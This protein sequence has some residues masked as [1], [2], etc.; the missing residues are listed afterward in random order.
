MM[1][2]ELV[3]LPTWISLG[4]IAIILTVT[5]VA[6]LRAE[7]RDPT[8]PEPRTTSVV[9][10]SAEASTGASRGTSIMQPRPTLAFGDD[11]S[12]AA[13]V[14][15]LWII[16]HTWTGWRLEIITAQGAPI[17]PPP[18][19]EDATL[20]H[21]DP[22]TPRRPFA[23]TAFGDV[24]HLTA[25]IDPRLALWRPADLLV[26]GPRGPG[27]LKALHLGSTAEWLLQH[28]IAP[29]VIARSGHPARKVV[30]CHDG[31]PTR[32]VP[33]NASRSSP[34]SGVSK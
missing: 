15:W 23:E 25:E 3:H 19:P 5:I 9:V 6:S 20:H 14:S 24:E 11:G 4:V 17:G 28:P 29:L 1:A 33:S 8:S 30:A 7:R 34:G 13:D 12:P 27:L 10:P 21:W 22:P 16:S 18:T 26:I 2:V 32:S 31:P